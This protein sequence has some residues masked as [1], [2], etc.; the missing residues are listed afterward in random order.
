MKIDTYIYIEDED[1]FVSLD[2][3]ERIKDFIKR[4][5]D[6]ME[7]GF[8]NLD[9]TITFRNGENGEIVEFEEADEISPL[10]SYYKNALKDY[11]KE[12]YGEVYYPN[13]PLE[14]KFEASSNREL[15]LSLE[16]QILVCNKTEFLNEFYNAGNKFVDLINYLSDGKYESDLKE[17][18]LSIKNEMKANE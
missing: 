16:N 8:L 10:W 2:E 12:G 4:K 9:G 6:F 15:I 1:E 11:L 5:K 14:I 7:D 3:K 18:L 13:S 17:A